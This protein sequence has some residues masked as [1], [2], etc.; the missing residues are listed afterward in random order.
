MAAQSHAQ[1]NWVTCWLS[2]VAR[3][4]NSHSKIESHLK[5]FKGVSASSLVRGELGGSGSTDT[6]LAVADGLVG[7]GELGEIVTNHVGLDLDWVPVLATVALDNR[8]AHLGD[9]DA[10]SEVSL[11]GLWLL[12]CWN[13]LL[14]LSELLHEAVILGLDTTSE[15][16]SLSGIHQSN[17]LLLGHIK[18]FVQLVTSV[19]LL[20]EGFLNW[21]GGC[22][23]HSAFILLLFVSQQVLN[24]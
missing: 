16:P 9:D 22:L 11:D 13:V 7:H 1:N 12:A 18:E 2:G 10:V 20:S 24:Q 21:C 15:S 4:A 23:R 3:S 19:D 8:V 14:G 17:D 5:S 6:N